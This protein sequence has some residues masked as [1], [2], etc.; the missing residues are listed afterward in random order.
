MEQHRARRKGHKGRRA[1]A[2]AAPA[3][4]TERQTAEERWD[5]RRAA[6]IGVRTAIIGGPIAGSVVAMAILSRIL[7]SPGAHAGVPAR[8]GWWTVIL[9]GSLAAMWLVDR[10]TRRLAPLAALLDMAVLFPGRAPT[11]LKVARKAGDLRQLHALTEQANKI[12]AQAGVADAA[13]QIL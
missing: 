11:R 8:V 2:A 12:D 4:S 5:R 9:V 6:A 10:A 1:S 13:E 3:L 7:P